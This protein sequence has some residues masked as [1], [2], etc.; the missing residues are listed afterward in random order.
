MR[1]HVLYYLSEDYSFYIY[2][3]ENDT[4]TCMFIKLYQALSEAART[5]PCAI[6]YYM[7]LITADRGPLFL[8]REQVQFGVF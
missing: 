1:S 4:Y 6:T 2:I 7:V 5:M 8:V 3:V